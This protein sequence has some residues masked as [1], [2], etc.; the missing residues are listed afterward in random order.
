[1]QSYQVLNRRPYMLPAGL[2]EKAALKH[3]LHAGLYSFVD[4]PLSHTMRRRSASFARGQLCVGRPE[5]SFALF[6]MGE[7]EHA[8]KKVEPEQSPVDTLLY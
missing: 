1:M 6:R 4:S 8:S 5:A 3:V 7:S 2:L